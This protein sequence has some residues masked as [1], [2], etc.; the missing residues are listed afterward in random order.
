[1]WVLFTLLCYFFTTSNGATPNGWETHLS[2]DLRVYYYN[3]TLDI[4]QWE[5]PETGYEISLSPSDMEKGGSAEKSQSYEQIKIQKFFLRASEPAN[6]GAI[7]LSLQMDLKR[8]NRLEKHAKRWNGPITAAILVQTSKLDDF[9]RYVDLL[10]PEIKKRVTIHACISQSQWR[11]YPINFMR[12]TALEDISTQWTFVIDS[13]ED[14]V[15][16]MSVYR[17]EVIRAIDQH[18]SSDISKTVFTVTSWQWGSD[19]KGEFPQSRA[20]LK[21]MY[22]AHI[23]DVKAPH[24][25]QAYEPPSLPLSKWLNL[26]SAQ[27]TRYADNYEPYYII[28]TGVAPKFDPRFKGWGGNKVIQSLTMAVNRY[29]FLVLPKVFTFVDDTPKQS[30]NHAPPSDPHLFDIAWKE[31]GSKHGCGSCSVWGCVSVCPWLVEGE[32]KATAVSLSSKKETEIKNNDQIPILSENKKED[33]IEKQQVDTKTKLPIPVSP[34]S[35]NIEPVKTKQLIENPA[36]VEQPLPQNQ[37][38]LAPKLI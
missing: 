14:T 6:P 34:K 13:D 32:G 38:N 31:I 18:S 22:S 25:H 28:R 9:K 19:K 1:M 15:F 24:F 7:T 12:N 8:I 20:A 27:Y 26:E 11:H 16:P 30:Q 4:S 35:I 33:V 17:D 36:K 2:P 37:V 5:K 21:G 29:K 10:N 23:I 3:P